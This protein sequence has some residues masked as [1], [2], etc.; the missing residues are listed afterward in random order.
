MLAIALK[1]D[2]YLGILLESAGFRQYSFFMGSN[3]FTDIIIY[4]DSDILVCHKRAGIATEGARAGKQDL[5][6]MTRNYLAR[7]ENRNVGEAK[8]PPYVATVHRLDQPVEGVIVMAKT[9]KAATSLAKQIKD[10]TTG[11]YYYALCHGEFPEDKGTLEDFITRT[12]EGFAK[13]CDKDTDDAKKAKLDFEVIKRKD[14]YSLLN[15][16][17]LTG[18]FHQIRCQLSSRGYPIVGDHRYGKEDDAPIISLV[19]YK[20]ELIHPTTKKKMTFEIEP[21][22]ALIKALL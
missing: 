22:N 7:K 15:I 9:K 18:R 5:V 21:D 17:L 10:R 13:I 20:F 19:S 1:F 11:K 12:P 14:G 3:M 6:S 4:E 16:K 8:K 2:D